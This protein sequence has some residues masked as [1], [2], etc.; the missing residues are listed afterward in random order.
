MVEFQPLSMRWIYIE[1]NRIECALAS[2]RDQLFRRGGSNKTSTVQNPL[3]VRRAWNRAALYALAV[4]V[5][6][7][8]TSLK[9]Y[10][11]EFGGNATPLPSTMVLRVGGYET[12]VLVK[13]TFIDVR[14][15]FSSIGGIASR[16]IGAREG[17]SGRILAVPQGLHTTDTT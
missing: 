13:H 14:A 1:S 12:V 4:G 11:H 8:E 9:R 6:K 3:E 15:D 10:C 17:S 2:L 7:V 16:A 5:L